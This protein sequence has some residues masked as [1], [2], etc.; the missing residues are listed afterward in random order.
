[1]ASSLTIQVCKCRDRNL[2]LLQNYKRLGLTSRL[3][4]ATGGTEKKKKKQKKIVVP[5]DH[6]AG[7]E[8]DDDDNDDRIDGENADGLAIHG[9]RESARLVPAEVKVERDALTG[10]ILRVV[11]A[12]AGVGDNDDGTSG[13]QRR[14][15][16]RMRLDD[17]LNSDSDSKEL[18]EEDDD[19]R[20]ETRHSSTKD[21]A[22]AAAR[23]LRQASTAVV[24]ALEA[25]AE[26][27]AAQL[28]RT[29]R[30]RKQ[31]KREEE[32]I[33]RLVQRHGEDVRAMARDRRLNPMQQTEADIGRR[34]RKWRG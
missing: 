32:W 27:E 31:S 16:R 11:G 10:R 19:G 29:K 24:A 23:N 28:A 26:E 22:A 13:Q 2:T 1:M 30:P 12:E 17:P 8:N 5:V 25:Q 18:G 15:W 20:E 7:A 14:N 34:V 21:A 4:G 3:N 33:A 6:V 9:K